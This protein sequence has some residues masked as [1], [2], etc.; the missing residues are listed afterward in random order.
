VGTDI[1]TWI[2]RAAYLG[3]FVSCI[4]PPRLIQPPTARLQNRTVEDSRRNEEE[5]DSEEMMALEGSPAL[6]SDEV[7]PNNV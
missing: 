5:E 2:N 4:I 7:N 6:A 1:P 3:G